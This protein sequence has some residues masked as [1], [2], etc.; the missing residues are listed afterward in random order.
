MPFE[1]AQF[2]G[3]SFFRNAGS[4][5]RYGLELYANLKLNKRFNITSSYTY[6]DFD[7]GDY[8]LENDNLNGNNLPGIPEH[9]ATLG[10]TYK[11]DNGLFIQLDNNYRGKLFA[12]DQNATEV[13]DAFI[14]NLNFNYP[15][16]WEKINLSLHGGV[17]NLFDTEY[18]DNIR[19]NAFGN[20]YYE[21]APGINVYAGVKVRI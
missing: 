21:P 10:L 2:Q 6:S 9:L 20:R 18:F 7:Y 3:R 11:T 16:K 13:E 12:D 4:T 14:A 19:I 5:D 17:N 8:Q 1:L 15:L